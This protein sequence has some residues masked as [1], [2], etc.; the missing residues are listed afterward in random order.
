MEI[1]NIQPIG[2]C[3]YSS[4]DFPS[5]WSISDFHWECGHQEYFESYSLCLN[6]PFVISLWQGK[7]CVAVVLL[8]VDRSPAFPLSL[9]WHLR[10]EGACLITSVWR[11]DLQLHSKPLLIPTWLAG[12]EVSLAVSHLAFTDSRELVSSP[13]TRLWWNSWPSTSSSEK[14]CWHPLRI[15]HVDESSGFLHGPH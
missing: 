3:F 9:H 13:P 1:W 15:L 5:S 10:M 8:C 12:E 7:V 11:W 4:W 2:C 6:W 14:S